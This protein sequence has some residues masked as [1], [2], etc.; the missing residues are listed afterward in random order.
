[1]RIIDGKLV[2]AGGNVVRPAG[3][4]GSQFTTP[5]KRS[6]FRWHIGND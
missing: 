1:M 6:I 2:D 3:G 4:R 5:S